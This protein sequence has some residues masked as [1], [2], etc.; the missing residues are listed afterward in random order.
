MR[1]R[2][3]ERQDQNEQVV[4][5][6][7]VE[8]LTALVFIAMALALVLR[9][10]ALRD[11]NPTQERMQQLQRDI[12]TKDA[13]I[14]ELEEQVELLNSELDAQ[15]SLVARL[16]AN[17]GAPLPTNEHVVLPRAEYDELRN[18]TQV[19]QAQQQ[20]IAR[21]QREIA[22]LRGGG[23]VTLPRCITNPGM[24]I[25]VRLNGDGSFSASAAYPPESSSSVAQIDGLRELLGGSRSRTDFSRF[26]SR[27]DQ[28]GER[29]TP[30]C[31]FSA[32]VVRGHSNIDL[33]LRQLA[34]VEQN[35]YVRRA[36]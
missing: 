28:W 8:F 26:A 13:R 11:L 22:I 5:F 29:Q 2:A 6:T 35:F 33:Y 30:P 4:T 3:A 18:A 27:I 1:S 24:L 20:D 23:S 9:N 25:N 32:L 31:A 19:A 21:L 17:A 15:R 12:A 16:M 7:L 34:V 36:R 10:E 14:R